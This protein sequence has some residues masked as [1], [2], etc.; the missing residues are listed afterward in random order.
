[1]SIEAAIVEQWGNSAALH[2]LLPSTSVSSGETL[3]DTNTNPSDDLPRANVLAETDALETTNSLTSE[4]C[5]ITLEVFASTNTAI[6]AIRAAIHTRGVFH[7][8]SWST[9]ELHVEFCTVV[10]SLKERL[11]G[12]DWKLTTELELRFNNL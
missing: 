4:L 1:M 3:S 11:P 6:N 7:H 5:L 12:G 9:D 10:N 2:A 8:A